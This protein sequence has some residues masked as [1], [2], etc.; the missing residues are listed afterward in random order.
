MCDLD[1]PI[2][3]GVI[4]NFEEHEIWGLFIQTNANLRQKGDANWR[5]LFARI[6]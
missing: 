3:K 4:P 6:N 5:S 2:S 1:L